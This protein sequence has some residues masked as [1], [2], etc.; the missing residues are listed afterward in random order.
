MFEKLMDRF[1]T[2]T[3]RKKILLNLEP[4]EVQNI[5][6]PTS[7]HISVFHLEMHLHHIINICLTNFINFKM[8]KI[9]VTA[10]SHNCQKLLGD[11]QNQE[12]IF[13]A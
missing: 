1:I 11:P 12:V 10:V 2:Y 6:D 8:W 13:Q 4:M 7:R 5:D 9:L 3:P